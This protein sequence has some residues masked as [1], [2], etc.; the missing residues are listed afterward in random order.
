MDVP[1]C[2]IIDSRCTPT[3]ETPVE[4]GMVRSRSAL[5]GP[6]S[7][8]SH[9]TPMVEPSVESRMVGSRSAL[10]V[11][12]PVESRVV[13]S[14]SSDSEVGMPD[15][16]AT[17]ERGDRTS[18]GLGLINGSTVTPVYF[19]TL[20]NETARW[21]FGL[22]GD[23][24]S[25]SSPT[26]QRPMDQLVEKQPEE[27]SSMK[28]HSSLYCKDT[29]LHSNLCSPNKLLENSGRTSLCPKTSVFTLQGSRFI[30]QII[31]GQVHYIASY[32]TFALIDNELVGDPVVDCEETMVS[33]TFKTKKP[34]NG[35]VYVQGQAEDERCSRNF[36]S[37]ADQSKFSMMIQ[38]GDCTMQRQRVT[39][40]LEGMMLSLT[41]VAMCFFKN[42][43]HL[44]NAIDVNLI[45]TTELLDTAKTLDVCIPFMPKARMALHY[46]SR[47]DLLDV[48]GCAIDPI[49]Q[50]DVV[51]D[52]E[53]NRASV[54]TF[55]Y[56]FSDTTVLNYQCT[57]ELC[58]KSANECQGLS[59]PICGRHKSSNQMDLL[60][61][62]KIVENVYDGSSSDYYFNTVAADK[63]PFSTANLVELLADYSSPAEAA[64]RKEDCLRSMVVGFSISLLTAV[65]LLFLGIAV[66]FFFRR[67]SFAKYML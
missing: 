24:I 45:G 35:R 37:N 11:E 30:T 10:K 65:C 32:T 46:R 44:T 9:C 51:Y 20:P 15:K 49:I 58:K 33:L 40:T 7:R 39:G 13:R 2:R 8:S 31:T 38:N 29:L 6:V 17:P 18:S 55:G 48:D 26:T 52:T 4:S 36:A 67:D 19:S 25:R 53:I 66:F 12:S 63:S 43:K 14:R 16:T 34:F 56:K 62:V 50:P 64:F 5:G 22:E 59:P 61:S 21:S 27:C 1:E 60:A 23:P 28:F 57:I 54:E 41:I 42:I 3:I 47:F